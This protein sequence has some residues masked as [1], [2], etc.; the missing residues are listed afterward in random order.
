VSYF[1]DLGETGTLDDPNRILWGSGTEVL[2]THKT[3]SYTV[4]AWTKVIFKFVDK[5]YL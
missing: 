2:N 1:Y 5:K 3:G 4:K